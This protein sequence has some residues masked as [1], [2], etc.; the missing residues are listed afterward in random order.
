MIGRQA[1]LSS[2]SSILLTLSIGDYLLSGAL[3]FILPH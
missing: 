1:R 3:P 2:S